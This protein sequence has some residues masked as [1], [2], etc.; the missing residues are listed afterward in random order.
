MNYDGGYV[1]EREVTRPSTVAEPKSA[2]VALDKNICH[3]IELDS[4]QQPTEMRNKCTTDDYVQISYLEH[5]LNIE[6]YKC[7]V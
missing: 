7:F 3:R 6:N 1:Y 5:V 4:R 2:K